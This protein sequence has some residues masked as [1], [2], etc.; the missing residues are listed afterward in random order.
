[1][2]RAKRVAAALALLGHD[3][4]YSTGE[5]AGG[6]DRIRTCGGLPH[7]RFPGVPIKPLWHLSAYFSSRSGSATNSSSATVAIRSGCLWMT[8]HDKEYGPDSVCG[9][10]G[11]IRTRD[12]LADIPVFETG[13]F[14]HSATS[15]DAIHPG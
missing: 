11:G 15:P 1:M 7:I 3:A 10:E 8:A 5:E 9:G 6:E 2:K 4:K 12:T 13:A 14:N